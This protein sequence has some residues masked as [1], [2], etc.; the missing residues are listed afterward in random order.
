MATATKDSAIPAG[1]TVLVTGCNGL[2]GSHIANQF[3]ERGFRVR[4]TV[5]D[6]A[7]NVWMTNLLDSQYGKGQF[8]LFPLRDMAAP[9]AFDEAVKGVSAVVH[10]A[11]IMTLAHDP[12]EV[13]PGAVDFALNAIKAAYSEPSTK[14][15]V[16][17]SSSSAAVLAVTGKP[18]IVVTEETYNEQAVVEAWAPPP[19]TPE[20]SHAVYSASK[21]L[22]EQ[23]IW[24]YY[25]ENAE[26]RPDIVVN[27]VLP[28]MTLGKSLDPVNQGYSST[29][30]MVALLYQGQVVDYHRL[31]PRQ[32][33]VDV[34][35][36]GRLHVAAAILDSV[37]G[38]RIFGFASRYNWDMILGILRKLLADDPDKLARI[39]ADFS[40][41]EDPNE[42]EPR[43]EAERIL[44]EL[45]RPGWTSLEE[46]IA[47]AVEGLRW[48][49][50]SGKASA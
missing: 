35:D 1:S 17:C 39:P 48:L 10:S 38:R 15:F 27:T 5:R 8:E 24:K 4:G 28:N 6:A 25:R 49:E 14:R 30:G 3:L 42:I 19:Y 44:K 18:G 23:A 20:R 34:Q 37:R 41:G 45:G 7:K 12:N 36:I 31:V 21:T 26:R 9:G 50:D 46:S 16:F 22:A 11:S 13:I 47:D 29:A 33:F 43:A 2:I 32:Y 40:G